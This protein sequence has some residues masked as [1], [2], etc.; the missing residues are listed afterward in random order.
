MHCAR[1][2]N[3]VVFNGEIYNY[4]HLRNELCGLGWTF[5]SSS[6]TEVLLASYGQWGAACLQRLQGMFAF[7]IFDR[8]SGR[9][10]LARDRMGKKPLFYTLAGQQLAW[11]SEIK[12]LLLLRPSLARR[13]SLS[14]LRSYVDLGYVA[15]TETIYTDIKK[16]PP[17]H[18]ATFDL[19]TR[20]FE[21][22]QYWRLPCPD[23]GTRVAEEGA[24]QL[25]EQLLLD[26]IRLRLE[27]DVPLGVFLSGGL[28]SSIVA[29]LAG[30]LKPGLLA[31][32]VRFPSSEFDESQIAAEVARHANLTHQVI[33]V[34]EGDGAVLEDVLRTFDEP[35]ADSSLLP[36][37]LISR[38]TR[39]QVTVA[40]SGDGGDELFAGYDIYHRVLAES[41]IESLPQRLRDT[42]GHLHTLLNVGTVGKNF[43]RRL[44]LPSDERFLHLYRSPEEVSTA[45]LKPDLQAELDRLPVD[46]FRRR[47]ALEDPCDF[48]E[49][50]LLQRM[51]RVDAMSY[52]PDDV[53]V[54]VDRA[55]MLAS[56]E[57]RSP[58]LDH[59]VV[60]LAYRLPDEL[61][62]AGGQRKY[63]L[64]VI[65]RT[66][67]P[68]SFPFERKRGFSI[69]EADWIRGRWR[70]M[71]EEAL[72]GSS[73]L[74]TRNALSLLRDH[75]RTGRHGRTLF[76]L[77]S[78]ALFERHSG[79]SFA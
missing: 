59:R 16:L 7:A 70:P 77:F 28:D 4:R 43:L 22:T 62:Y 17:G 8:S 50:S 65:G 78:L 20:R 63:L 25:L 58:L 69:P 11:A 30:R 2:G 23:P 26:A 48:R 67:L 72:S 34:D 40:L 32:T 12:A 47:L 10:V 42:V 44:P 45:L 14:G 9:I 5:Y 61:R 66:I 31:Y 46:G 33:D 6:D 55:S 76:K 29:T 18:Y 1:T 27:S 15:G 64:K 21:L 37:Y 41:F 57:V 3:V 56:L 60:E 79:I 52:L 38:E 19:G 75:D 49:L 71:F 51:T 53:L 68:K 36:T 73:L 24:A 74:N 54:K 39:R 13:G 35:F